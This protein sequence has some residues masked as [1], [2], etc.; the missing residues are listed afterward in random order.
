MT[1]HELTLE[2]LKNDL[3]GGRV[4]EAFALEL[5]RC[6]TDCEDR[7]GDDKARKVTL[8]IE[9]KPA[10]DEKGFCEN[11]WGQVKVTSAVPKRKTKPISFG[12]RRGGMLVFNDLSEDDFRQKTI[13]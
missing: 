5:K 3:A 9:L 10:T 7:P 2:T 8:E 11:V 6:V 1:V 12:V 4:G 13:E